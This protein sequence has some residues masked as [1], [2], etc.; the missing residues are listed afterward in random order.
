[1]ML[2]W[3]ACSKITDESRNKLIQEQKIHLF[4]RLED[5][6]GQ[7]KKSEKWF[8][9]TGPKYGKSNKSQIMLEYVVAL[10]C[11]KSNG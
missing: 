7:M 1:M 2:A 4:W 5:T 6:N 10:M 8:G 11:L 9:H 3:Y